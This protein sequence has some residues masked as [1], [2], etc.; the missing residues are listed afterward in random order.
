MPVS[1]PLV[2]AGLRDGV[3]GSRSD[4]MPNPSAARED[5][6]QRQS[7][8]HVVAQ[9]SP[10]PSSGAGVRIRAALER[11]G[12]KSHMGHVEISSSSETRQNAAPVNIT[13]D[14]QRLPIT[15]D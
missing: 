14:S 2:S 4:S 15:G 9:E 5:A 10:P 3:M 6:Q 12:C 13:L 11:T 7:G 8:T 1:V